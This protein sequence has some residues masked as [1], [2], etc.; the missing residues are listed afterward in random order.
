MRDDGHP[1]GS[2]SISK[3][4]AAEEFGLVEIELLPDRGPGCPVRCRAVISALEES[5][6]PLRASSW[7]HDLHGVLAAQ[8]VHCPRGQ[9]LAE[10]CKGDAH[11]R[12]PRERPFLFGSKFRGSLHEGRPALDAAVPQLLI[13]FGTSTWHGVPAEE[14]RTDAIHLNVSIGSSSLSLQEELDARISVHSRVWSSIP[15]EHMTLVADIE[16]HVERFAVIHQSS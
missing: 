15:S 3:L 13:D 4:Q 12:R 10:E 6:A 9:Q 14:H 5:D 16:T 7:C 1:R 8:R 11:A 2:T